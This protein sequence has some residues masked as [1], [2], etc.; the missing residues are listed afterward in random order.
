[1]TVLFCQAYIHVVNTSDVHLSK[2]TNIC[3]HSF[4]HQ[5]LLYDDQLPFSVTNKV[6]F[7]LASNHFRK[8]FSI[9]AGVW[10]HMENKF[11]EKYFQLIVCFNGFDLEMVWSENFHFKPFLDS[12]AK[13]DTEREKERERNKRE[14]SPQTELQSDD[15]HSTS[16]VDRSTAPIAP[17]SSTL[18]PLDLASAARSLLRIRRAILPLDRTKSPL[19]LPSSLSLTGFDEFFF[20]VLF[21]LCFCIDRIW[22][23]FFGFCFFCISV[24]TRFDECFSW[25]LF[26]LCFCIEEWYYIFVWQLRKYEKMWATSRKCIFYDIFKNITKHQKIF[27]KT[28]FEMQPNTWK[29]FPFLKIAFPE[30][31]YFPENILHEPNTA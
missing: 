9:N 2:W 21:L 17:F 4:F 11:S 29:Y 13:T 3:I 30:N 1:M 16:L 14:P 7:L 20:S 25:V 31:I 6:V 12:C 8:C 10:L 23:I 19:S 15:P 18:T 5:C 22:W 24:L 28:F 27:F 26:L